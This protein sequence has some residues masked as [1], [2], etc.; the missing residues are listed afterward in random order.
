MS[1]PENDLERALLRAQTEEDARPEFY[2]LLMEAELFV[3]G[4]V[5]DAAGT[6][7]EGIPPG[8]QL[9]LAGIEHDGHSYHLI[10]T[11]MKRLETFAGE[12]AS[13]FRIPARQLFLATKGAHFMLNAGDELGK[14]LMPDEID[15]L[16]NPPLPTEGAV[17]EE[18]T[19]VKLSHPSPYPHVLVKALKT[20]FAR[21][22][23]VLAAHLLTI[24]YNDNDYPHPLI[25]VEVADDWPGVSKEIGNVLK[26]ANAGT[27]VDM[28]PLNRANPEG[29]ARALLETPPFYASESKN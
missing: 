13:Y 9:R 1:S 10:F 16:L 4:D 14:P 19:R 23:N 18:G 21:N 11:S 20:M 3:I 29:V 25:G 17:P 12:P 6:K 22:P 5:V 15:Y 2:R 7:Q 8:A 24:S 28:M 27:V 26:A